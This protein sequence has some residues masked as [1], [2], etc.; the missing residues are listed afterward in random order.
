MGS[1]PPEFDRDE[2]EP[3]PIVTIE[4]TPEFYRN[5]RDL[6]KRYRHIRADPDCHPGFRSGDFCRR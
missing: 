3:Q 1:E 5:L 2:V 6:N 4:L